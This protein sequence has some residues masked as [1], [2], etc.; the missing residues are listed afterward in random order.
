MALY[1]GES[2]ATCLRYPLAWGLGGSQSLDEEKNSHHCPCHELNP[3]RL[4]RSLVTHS[5]MIPYMC[6]IHSRFKC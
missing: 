4:A 6:N 1:G 2:S 5:N 3:G